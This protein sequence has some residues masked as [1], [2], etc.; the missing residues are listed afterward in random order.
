MNKILLLLSLALLPFAGY[1]QLG[2]TTCAN[3]VQICFEN[4]IAYP[5]TINEGQAE[6]GPAYGCL[7]S[8]PNPAWFYFQVGTPGPHQ[9]FITNSM[10]RDLDFII[11]GPFAE[12]D[13]WCDSLTVANT[14][15]CS[16]AGGTTETANF[17]SLN[18]GDIYVLLI[19]NYS[20]QNTNV[21]IVQNA[22]TG[23][24]SCN[25]T[26]PCI[27]SLVTATPGTCDT[28]TNQYSVSGQVWGFNFP[29]AGQLTI[30][31]GTNTQ[32]LQ[33][34]FS[35]P[36]SFSFTGLP[37]NGQ[38][39]QITAAFSGASSCSGTG[40]FTA[41]SGCIPCVA[42]ASGNSP[43][44]E[45]DS[46]FL[47]I[48]FDQTATYQWSGPGFFTSQQQNPV[49]TANPDVAAGVYTVLING[50]NCVSER[51]VAIEITE[52]PIPQAIAVETTVCEGD[53]LFMGAVDVLGGAYTWTGPN[54]FTAVTRNTQVNNTTVASSGD[55][56]LT[57][58]VNGC[59][60]GADT[61]TA[62][63]IAAPT[64]SIDLP[65]FVNPQNGN[66]V[67]YV[68]GEPGLT[69]QWNFI[70]N[71]TL[72]TASEFNATGDSVLISW[73]GGEGIMG[74]QVIATDANGCVSESVQDI[75]EVVIPLEANTLTQNDV[76]MYPNP[77]TD[78]LNLDL[79]SKF[80]VRIYDAKGT[81]VYAAILNKGRHTL[82]CSSWSAGMYHMHATNGSKNIVN[83]NFIVNRN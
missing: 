8:R 18:S 52:A 35:S 40:S 44:C 12:G 49:I 6:T 53:I 22:G 38:A 65:E 42:N 39:Q 66:S 37:S 43:V 83:R 56:L 11:Y 34:P 46:I 79:V 51:S 14:A 82:P 48:D 27:T 13:D 29:D 16:Y 21:N 1:S 81:L 32:T 76:Q 77:A 72:I 24:F 3:A 5:A 36:V 75:C 20:N 74:A 64:L 69:Y 73:D 2:N 25:F 28:L 30:S 23:S 26:A 50:P 45:G 47:S 68:S 80:D 33:G 10:N 61:V 57:L 58:S 67:F 17:T 78:F 55:Y 63:V 19:T 59:S 71:T 62:T 54:G 60:N 41:P 7:S 4:P 15:D 31:L 9:L 70:G